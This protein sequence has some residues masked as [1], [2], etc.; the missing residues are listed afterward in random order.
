MIRDWAGNDSS[1]EEDDELG[2]AGPGDGERSDPARTSGD[3]A[4]GEVMGR[5]D[6]LLRPAC[7]ADLIGTAFVA[8]LGDELPPSLRI[9][10][11]ADVFLETIGLADRFI[12]VP[13]PSSLRGNGESLR[14]KADAVR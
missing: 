7:S 9:D 2:S 6:N 13:V 10:A 3:L 11:F 5:E 14:D 8:G 1:S 4:M 12:G